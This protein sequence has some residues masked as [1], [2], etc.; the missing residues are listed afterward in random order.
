MMAVTKKAHST[1][2][3][4]PLPRHHS[5]APLVSPAPHSLQRTGTEPCACG[6]GCPRCRGEAQIQPKLTIGAPGDAFEQEADRIADQV[7]RMP[8]PHLRASS[9]RS[10]V[11]RKCAACEEEKEEKSTLHTK[12]EPSDAG[13]AG[14]TAPPIVH[15]VLGASGQPLDA[16]TRAFMEPRFGRDFGSV[17]MHLDARPQHRRER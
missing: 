7:M 10:G 3:S 9:A 15:E 5:H 13:A 14:A 12:R 6:G 2:R 17:R 16:E 4:S 8:D 11:Q 1:V